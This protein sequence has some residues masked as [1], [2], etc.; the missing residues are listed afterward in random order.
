MTVELAQPHAASKASD[1]RFKSLHGKSQSQPAVGFQSILSAAADASSESIP[2]GVQLLRAANDAASKEPNDSQHLQS[3]ALQPDD[4]S[5]MI[6]NVVPEANPSTLSP[7]TDIAGATSQ[8]PSPNVTEQVNALLSQSRFSQSNSTN[9]QQSPAQPQ[10]AA[11]SPSVSPVVSN[12][13]VPIDLPVAGFLQSNSANLQPQLAQPQF[14]ASSLHQAPVLNHSSVKTD[15]PIAGLSHNATAKFQLSSAL[16]QA[17]TPKPESQIVTSSAISSH[18]L[19]NQVI[20]TVSEVQDQNLPQPQTSLAEPVIG[21][22]QE[23]N[24]PMVS[25]A[26]EGAVV[27]GSDPSRLP[28]MQ[29]LTPLPSTQTAV[30]PA[31]LGKIS[32]TESS[33][34]TRSTP[35]SKDT[36]PLATAKPSHNSLPDA[37]VPMPQTLGALP[38]QGQSSQAVAS[39]SN[40]EIRALESAKVAAIQVSPATLFSRLAVQDAQDRP[41]RASGFNEFKPWGPGSFVSSSRTSD[42]SVTSNAKDVSAG[43]G[44]S[45][46][47]PL[48][49]IVQ[50][51]PVEIKL[52]QWTD[53]V[54]TT[55][56][57]AEIQV[58]P[59]VVTEREILREEHAVFKTNQPDIVPDLQTYTPTGADNTFTLPSAEGA[60]PMETYVAEQVTYWIN[61]NVHNAELKLEGI[62]I[63]PVQVNITM[64]GNEAFVTFTTDEQQAREALENARQQ[65]QDMLQSQGVILSG[66][67]VGSNS[68]GNSGSQS[69]DRN[70]RQGNKQ[71]VVASVEPQ[72][73]ENRPRAGRTSGSTLDLFV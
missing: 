19:A 71:T 70:P 4:H 16:D 20:P 55:P 13:P 51:A 46:M 2:A 56:M 42:S 17:L 33:A 38:V 29:N 1:S 73:Q 54:R 41:A 31:A 61:Q 43:S 25:V 3:L 62:G 49:T 8:T 64:Q 45:T 63:D 50:A 52:N 27:T 34:L 36:V 66:L 28:L 72:M 68:A 60:V 15:L 35:S 11:S 32:Q 14:A 57:A 65:L 9:V 37:S 47:P 6:Q 69:Q 7:K 23:F 44:A 24:A 21:I 18:S 58:A 26:T 30:S 67:S 22:P 48:A 40:Q 53:P 10:W 5:P 12:S 39:A 59:T